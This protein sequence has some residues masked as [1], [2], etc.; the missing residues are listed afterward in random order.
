MKAS[1]IM[2]VF[3]ALLTGCAS[4]PAVSP[5]E[6][7][8]AIQAHAAQQV[9]AEALGLHDGQ[10]AQP[11]WAMAGRVALSNGQNG[12]SGRIE[13]VQGEGNI[14]VQLLAPVTRQSWQLE[15]NAQQ[16]ILQGVPQG[17]LYGADAGQLLRMATGWDVPV[18]AL[19][20]W[21]RAVAADTGRFGEPQ[22]RYD[23][24]LLPMQLVQAGWTVDYSQWVLD[25]FTQLQMPSRI[26][27]QRGHDRVRLIID[28]WGVE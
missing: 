11:G 19:G 24:H 14:H 6:G 10:C 5:Q 9:R 23:R 2:G 21:M 27:A 4:L 13:W 22:M 1:Q 8:D 17:P 18:E 3:G 12:G 26:Q 20:C 15:V 16:V 25:P 7:V 28:R